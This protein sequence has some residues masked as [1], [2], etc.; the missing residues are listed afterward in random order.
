[1]T[2]TMLEK[3]VKLIGKTLNELGHEV[4]TE[5]A[6]IR[7]KEEL[8]ILVEWARCDSPLGGSFFNMH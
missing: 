2:V 6:V 1:M 5:A 8:A 4:S 7:L 3:A